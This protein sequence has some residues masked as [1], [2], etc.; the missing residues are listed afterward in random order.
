M[1]S[2]VVSRSALRVAA[3]ELGIERR[4][5]RRSPPIRGV[6]ASWTCC[7]PTPG[8]EVYRDGYRPSVPLAGQQGVAQIASFGQSGPA[9][10]HAAGPFCVRLSCPRELDVLL[11]YVGS[12]GTPGQ[13][14]ASGLP[15]GK[16]TVVVHPLSI[17][18]RVVRLL[19]DSAEPVNMRPRRRQ[20]LRRVVLLRAGL[21]R[22]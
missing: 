18:A 13:C 7:C 3:G 12:H 1:T 20:S 4:R 5:F 22:S 10:P 11:V 14:T 21:G 9:V 17:S 15:S 8:P 6:R 19:N 16:T 2:A